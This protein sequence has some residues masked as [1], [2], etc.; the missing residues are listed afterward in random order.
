M[1]NRKPVVEGHDQ[2]KAPGTKIPLSDL[3]DWSDRDGSRDIV[4]FTVKD[5][6]GGGYLTRDGKAQPEGKTIEI[7][8][9]EIGR[10]A[11]VVG[12]KGSEDSIV[13]KAIDKA[14]T[15]D[16]DTAHVTAATPNSRPDVDGQ[17]LTKAA[18]AKVPLLDLFTVSDKDGLGDIRS[19]KV[20]DEKGGGYL[21]LKGK[22]QA[23][24]K[25]FTVDIN[26]LDDWTYVAGPAGS[27]DVLTLSVA[28]RAGASDSDTAVVTSRSDAGNGV[29]QLMSPVA[30]AAAWQIGQA[31]GG[32]FSHKGDI[33]HGWDFSLAG[34][35]DEFGYG[36]YAVADGIIKWV[37]ENVRDGDSSQLER[38]F[39]YGPQ[40]AL[41]NIVTI[42]HKVNG[43]TFY[44]SYFHLKESSVPVSMGDSVK[45]G[46][47]IGEIGNTGARDGTHLHLNLGSTFGSYTDGLGNSYD[48]YKIAEGPS[49]QNLLGKFDFIDSPRTDKELHTGNQFVSSTPASSARASSSADH[50][51]GQTGPAGMGGGMDISFDDLF[52]SGHLAFE[53]RLDQEN[54]FSH[55]SSGAFHES[56]ALLSGTLP[57]FIVPGWDFH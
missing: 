1:A 51:G 44:S 26:D 23:D 39:S 5:S 17:D 32:T 30:G 28:D 3:F 31:P 14:N 41:G 16:S 35:G 53:P 55:V 18:G 50:S 45:A 42:E 37:V 7:P 47:K 2:T 29:I 8:A 52:D 40:G 36:V 15:Y 34:G 49:S 9:G 25:T 57:Q 12:P 24:G 27:K 38:D 48:A 21:M 46:Q 4:S 11:F 6:K 19:V 22:A 54:V 20:S 56:D 43:V 10:W 33:Y 13:L